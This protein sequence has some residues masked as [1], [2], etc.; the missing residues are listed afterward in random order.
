M[1]P[2]LTFKSKAGFSIENV[3]GPST[4]AALEEA[5]KQ[6]GDGP[7]VWIRDG[8]ELPEHMALQPVMVAQS[9]INNALGYFEEES[10]F[11]TCMVRHGLAI[12]VA[13]TEDMKAYLE[14]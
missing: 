12:L 3:P 11:D 14:K 4:M 9:L 2:K 6:W 10:I 8:W 13:V 5:D 1:V 7:V